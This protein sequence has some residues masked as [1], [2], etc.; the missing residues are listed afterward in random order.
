MENKKQKLSSALMLEG[1][2]AWEISIKPAWHKHRGLVQGLGASLPHCPR[3]C[4]AT[5]PFCLRSF[6]CAT[7][8]VSAWKALSGLWYTRER[9]HP[10]LL[11]K[12]CCRGT[13][14]TGQ[15][16]GGFTA[17]L[18]A[19]GLRFKRRRE[20]SFPWRLIFGNTSAI[21]ELWQMGMAAV[22]GCVVFKAVPLLSA[23]HIYVKRWQEHLQTS[24]P[25][26]GCAHPNSSYQFLQ[27][28]FQINSQTTLFYF[29]LGN[30]SCKS[31]FS[32]SA[33]SNCGAVC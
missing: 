5:S 26:H 7:K 30:C 10:T 21:P 22:H 12:H 14:L 31:E 13:F 8:G 17:P 15:P 16:S 18:S 24:F 23:H 20:T 3:C 9:L 4:G 29:S 33:F 6:S 11:R 25:L 1:I 2:R 27:P 32:I 19:F 28:A